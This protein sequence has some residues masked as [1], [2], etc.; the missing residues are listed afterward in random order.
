MKSQ[1]IFKSALVTLAF[2]VFSASVFGQ[3][4]G[5]ISGIVSD[6]KTGE[7]LIGVSV[8]IAGTTKGVGTDVEGRYTLGGLTSGKYA[9]QVSYIGYAVKN[10]TEIE[11][12]EG[13][14]TA[15]N[16]ALEESTS[17][18]LNQV[19]ITST[20]KQESVNTLY[21]KQ[22]TNVSISDGISA[23]QTLSR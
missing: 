23:D 16:I 14:T 17:Q 6:K 7:T 13:A 11:V 5:K 12:K 22:K 1:I 3:A 2:L 8:K 21:L 20:V 4:T 18:T 15:L 19:V 9:I 10:I